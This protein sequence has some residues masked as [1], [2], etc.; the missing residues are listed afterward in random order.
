MRPAHPPDS[1][2]VDRRVARANSRHT[3]YTNERLEALG[4]SSPPRSGW[5]PLAA[6]L[7]V[8][9]L[10][11]IGFYWTDLVSFVIAIMNP[12]ESP[13]TPVMEDFTDILGPPYPAQSLNGSRY[14][15]GPTTGGFPTNVRSPRP[16][17]SGTRTEKPSPPSSRCTAS[18]C[19]ITAWPS[20]IARTTS[21]TS[22]AA[23]PIR[24]TRSS[25]TMWG[26]SW[27]W[28]RRPGRST[29]NSIRTGRRKACADRPS[30][31]AT[32]SRSWTIDRM[33]TCPWTSAATST[34]TTSTGSS[35]QRPRGSFPQIPC[36]PEKGLVFGRP[37]KDELGLSRS[38]R[39]LSSGDRAEF[40]SESVEDLC[41]SDDFRKR[42]ALV[43][44]MDAF[45]LTGSEDDRPGIVRGVIRHLGPV[46]DADDLRPREISQQSDVVRGRG[47]RGRRDLVEQPKIDGLPRRRGGFPEEGLDVV[48][49]RAGRMTAIEIRDA[50]VGDQIRFRP[51]LN[52]SQADR[53][54]L[55]R[56]LR[57]AVRFQLVQEPHHTIDCVVPEMRQAPMGTRPGDRRP[58]PEDSFLARDDPKSRRLADDDGRC[59]LHEIGGSDFH[60][61]LHRRLL[62]RREYKGDRKARV[63]ERPGRRQLRHASSF[64][65]R[66]PSSIQEIA[67]PG[68]LFPRPT[69]GNRHGVEVPVEQDAAG[70]ARR[71]DGVHVPMD[72]R[73]QAQV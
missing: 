39:G 24:T 62:V 61:P 47:H 38:P 66:R 70:P 30:G 18:T 52:S 20:T 57:T 17:L 32:Q 59:V 72:R 42:N 23:P 7:V 5:R 22:T 53:N 16:A 12:Q 28:G 2:S 63:Q 67:V 33:G 15:T 6:V 35:I 55:E 71:G 43:R 54:I 46:G 73:P 56:V 11:L 1:R 65:V 37:A 68:S 27:W 41:G 51:A 31:R 64:H 69:G 50:Q 9:A 29:S 44:D 4:V 3:S 10:V 13:C 36:G 60:G 14:R 40:L 34:G 21:S 49:R 19:A 58:V 26:I 8:I 45:R 25:A 48:L